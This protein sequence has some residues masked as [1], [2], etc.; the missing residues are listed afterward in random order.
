MSS[1]LHVILVMGFSGAGKSTVI[2]AL[3]DCLFFSVQGI[4]IEVISKT[5]TLFREHTPKYYKGL[6]IGVHPLTQDSS[7]RQQILSLKKELERNSIKTTLFFIEASIP[8]IIRRYSQT[9]RPHPLEGKAHSLEQ[10]IKQ[11]SF[12]YE[13]REIADLVIDTTEYTPHTLRKYVKEYS[14]RERDIF[15]LQFISFGFKYG[16]PQDADIVFDLRFLPNPYFV[17]ALRD[18]TG[19]NNDVQDFVFSHNEAIEAYNAIVNYCE[20][21]IP[22]YKKEGWHRVSIA[23]GCTGGKHRSVSFIERIRSHFSKLFCIHV[24]HRNISE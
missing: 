16:S 20:T 1:D 19:F 10:A 11:E 3:E 17:E 8:A 22:L 12:L 14:I 18:K 4:P 7:L 9:R 5:V 15:R 23:I 24:E 21:I 13:L 6:A 2:S